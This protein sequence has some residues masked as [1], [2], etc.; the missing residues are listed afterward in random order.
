MRHG[1]GYRYVTGYDCVKIPGYT[2]DFILTEN[3]EVMGSGGAH[4]RDWGAHYFQIPKGHQRY[5]E[6]RYPDLAS[7]DPDTKVKAWNKFMRS[8]DSEPY[9]VWKPQYHQ[10]G[11]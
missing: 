1:S 3:R 10:G 8:R 5:W 4:H 2:P 7:P 11:F 9:R 6:G